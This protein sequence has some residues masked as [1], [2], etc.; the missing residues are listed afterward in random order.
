MLVRDRIVIAVRGHSRSV[1]IS[2]IY[3]W[4]ILHVVLGYSIADLACLGL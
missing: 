4:P 1:V 2:E 3:P